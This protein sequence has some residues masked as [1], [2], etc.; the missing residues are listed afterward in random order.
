MNYSTSAT[1]ASNTVSVLLTEGMILSI[2]KKSH[3]LFFTKLQ[4]T[5]SPIFTELIKKMSSIEL[6]I[7][8]IIAKLDTYPMADN[9]NLEEIPILFPFKTFNEIDE[10]E[11]YL[12]ENPA[13][14]QKIV[15]IFF[16]ILISILLLVL[17]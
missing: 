4:F 10:F 7:N 2:L 3:F 15:N 13:V 16:T 14:K 5:D 17:F 11:K 6:K 9:F 8:Q 12:I 1:S